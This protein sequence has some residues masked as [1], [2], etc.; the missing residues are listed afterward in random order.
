MQ[1]LWIC[2]VLP[3]LPLEAHP[4]VTGAATV[5][6]GRD[7]FIDFRDFDPATAAST[8]AASGHHTPCAIHDGG[9]PRSRIVRA[10]AAASAAGI[11]PG[12]T[13]AQAQALLPGLRSYPRDTAA[14]TRRLEHLGAVAY[15][16]SSQVRLLPPDAVALEAGGSLRLFGGYDALQRELR[17]SLEQLGHVH[18]CAAAPNAL[19]ARVLAPLHDGIALFSDE[20][21]RRELARVPIERAHLDADTVA[22]LARLGLRRLGDVDVLTPAALAR[23]LGRPLLDTLDRLHGHIPDLASLYQPPNRFERRFE[24]DY[25]VERSGALV[26]PLQR[27]A[28]DF[29]AFLHARDGGVLHFEL[30]FDHE[31]H[32]PSR[33]HVGLR[34]PARDVD[35]LFEAVRGR[36]ER[37]ALPAA[38]QAVTWIAEDL[39]PFVPERFDLFDARTRGKLDLDTLAERLRTRLGDDAVRMLGVRADHR[40]ERA[41][42]ATGTLPAARARA[43]HGDA[44]RS[45]ATTNARGIAPPAVPAAPVRRPLWL[46]PHPIP[47]RARV[48]RLLEPDPERIESGWWDNADTR[49]DYFVAELDSGQRAW[50]YRTL[51]SGDDWMLHGWFA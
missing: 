3:M 26:F 45:T 42:F 21:M 44:P 51:G 47:L 48:L 31:D 17:A 15:G 24:F 13:L 16:F 27:L 35:A 18:H 50:I 22:A 7:G 46:L 14:E 11:V 8:P 25:G 20:H 39:P 9:A 36:L 41:W 2:F 28:R 5:A 4:S 23:R 38:V 34:K 29:A 32:P 37:L 10:N 30:R 40:P 33:I 43:D 49:R 19:A 1:S 6:A 12:L